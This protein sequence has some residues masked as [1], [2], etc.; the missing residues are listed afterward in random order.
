MASKTEGTAEDLTQGTKVSLV[1][2]ST[3]NADEMKGLGAQKK[4]LEDR[5]GCNLSLSRKIPQDGRSGHG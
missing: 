3:R 5:G 4:P 1:L 2:Q